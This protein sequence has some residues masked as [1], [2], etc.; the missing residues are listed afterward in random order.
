MLSSFGKLVNKEIEQFQVK[1]N[2]DLPTD[3]QKYL[4][5]NNGGSARDKIISFYAEEID[6]PIAIG[7]LF[8]LNHIK[9]GL[10]IETWQNECR[11]ELLDNMLVI[12]KTVFPGLI[13]LVNQEG[14]KGVYFWDYSCN[15]ED[16]SED[17]CLY[18]IANT[19]GEFL[20]SLFIPKQNRGMSIDYQTLLDRGYVLSDEGVWHHHQNG[21]TLQDVNAIMHYRFSGVGEISR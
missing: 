11:D 2:V 1:Y 3:Y 14:W 4:L 16:S 20:N 12:G 13:L 5:E 8:G 15:Y 17:A 9:R 19:F 6:E 18:F 21:K 10:S 7:A